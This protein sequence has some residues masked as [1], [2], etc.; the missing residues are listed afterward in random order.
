[1]T[2]ARHARERRGRRAESLTSWMLRLKGYRIL[3]RR[4]RT[5][6]GEIDLV[7][8]RGGTVVFVEVK[9]R[10]D[11]ETAAGAIAPRQ[12]N[13]ILAAAAFFVAA[14]PW[15]APLVQRFDAVLLVKGRWPRHVID[16]WRESAD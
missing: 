4:Y 13:R 12:Q 10:T 5:P 2:G 14:H 7:A 9:A 16:A 1:M 15:A 8:R 11:L 3:A 6:A